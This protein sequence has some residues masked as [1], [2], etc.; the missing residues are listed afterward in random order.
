MSNTTLSFK[1]KTNKNK[2]NLDRKY[3]EENK[4]V[5]D[6]NIPLKNN[7]YLTKLIRLRTYRET[8]EILK[9]VFIIFTFLLAYKV[10]GAHDLWV[11]LVEKYF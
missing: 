7:K 4:V 9:Y 10:V 3:A 1:D 11:Q 2:T 5:Q 6:H 8:L